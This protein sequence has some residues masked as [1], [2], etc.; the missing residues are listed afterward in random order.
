MAVARDTQLEGRCASRSELL[1]EED[2][3]TRVMNDSRACVTD[4]MRDHT[5]LARPRAAGPACAAPA[6]GSG[7]TVST[8]VVAG[9]RAASVFCLLSAGVAGAAAGTGGG[10]R[11]CSTVAARR[12]RW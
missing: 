11:R 6:A 9:R 5:A 8:L 4:P 10:G 12:Y 1:I 3:D 2:R 7:S